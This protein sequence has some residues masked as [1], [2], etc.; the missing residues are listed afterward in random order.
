MSTSLSL[1]KD[2]RDFLMNSDFLTELNKS[3]SLQ[4]PDETGNRG[5]EGDLGPFSVNVMHSG[6]KGM[7][8]CGYFGASDDSKITKDIQLQNL[9]MRVILIRSDLSKMIGSS[10]LRDYDFLSRVFTNNS[11]LV[12]YKT[13]IKNKIFNMYLLIDELLIYHKK[14]I[15]TKGWNSKF[16]LITKHEKRLDNGSIYH[17]YGFPNPDSECYMLKMVV[18]SGSDRTYSDWDSSLEAW[19]YSFWHRRYNEGTFEV[20][21]KILKWLTS[22][23]KPITKFSEKSNKA[24]NKDAK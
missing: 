24:I 11:I 18:D 6:I 22:N 15:E 17:K 14:I 13:V 21:E 10:H 2:K 8:Q 19:L 20:T 12:K 5:F 1:A 9:R 3:I 23:N 7:Y 16:D 4:L